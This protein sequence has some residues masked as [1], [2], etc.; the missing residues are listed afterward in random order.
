V[1]TAILVTC[2]TERW[3]TSLPGVEAL[4]RRAALAAI[5]GVAGRRLSGELGIVLADD[6]FVRRLNREYRGQDHPTN[7]LS[8][9]LDRAATVGDRLLGD[10]VLALGTLRREARQQRKTLR[11]H[12]L[13]LV[14]HGVLHLLGFDHDRSRAAKRMET[15]ER[16][17]L[18]GLGVDDPYAEKA[19]RPA[20]KARKPR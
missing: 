11:S 10:V 15:L 17:I 3:R 9:P 12:F 18:A 19:V 6:R 7:V 20:A 5:R 4:G 16:R 13:H 8:F 14:V 2:R 1:T